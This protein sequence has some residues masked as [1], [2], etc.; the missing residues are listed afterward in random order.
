M[1]I[2]ITS[3]RRSQRAAASDIPTRPTMSEPPMP[4]ALHG[5][6]R[7][8]QRDLGAIK[9][10]GLCPGLS[11]APTRCSDDNPG[12]NYD[13][14]RLDD[15][16]QCPVELIHEVPAKMRPSAGARTRPELAG[17]AAFDYQN[18]GSEHSGS[19]VLYPRSMV[20]PCANPTSASANMR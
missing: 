14:P 17:T 20:S 8:A 5:F 12:P 15:R 10:R 7:A 2:P 11:I 18:A 19:T 1:R 4:S 13:R 6:A 9:E 3:G 16:R